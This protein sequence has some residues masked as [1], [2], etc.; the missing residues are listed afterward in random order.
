MTTI[1]LVEDDPAVISVT[2][3]LLVSAGYQIVT[4]T[5]AED[6]LKRLVLGGIDIVFSDVRLGR[7]NDGYWLADEIHD[8]LPTLPIL[9][10]SGY[11]NRVRLNNW[12]IIY[13]PYL[14]RN[15]IAAI[16]AVLAGNPGEITVWPH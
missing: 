7:G 14:L 6:A 2:E 15:L 13:K 11:T 3:E 12:P 9:L 1:L 16:K 5:S 10:T 8:I 4:A